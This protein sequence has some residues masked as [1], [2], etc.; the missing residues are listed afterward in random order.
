MPRVFYL[1][2]LSPCLS[3]T[4]QY[5]QQTTEDTE[6]YLQIEQNIWPVAHTTHLIQK[7]SGYSRVSE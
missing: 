1:P 7:K 6:Q 2:K 4:I 5:M 3:K